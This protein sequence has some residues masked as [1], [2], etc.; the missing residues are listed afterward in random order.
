MVKRPLHWIWSRVWTLCFDA[1]GCLSKRRPLRLLCWACF[2]GRLRVA[3]VHEGGCS[4]CE[5]HPYLLVCRADL[6][7]R[8]SHWASS[9]ADSE[10]GAQ[11]LYLLLFLWARWLVPLQAYEEPWRWRWYSAPIQWKFVD[12]PGDLFAGAHMAVL[13][14]GFYIQV[15]CS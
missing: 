9:S 1:C 5:V 7:A 3:A 14:E 13:N 6:K 11:A 4:L 10:P 12:G 15:S 8:I 2:R